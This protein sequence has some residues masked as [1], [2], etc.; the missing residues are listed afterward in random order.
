MSLKNH[1]PELKLSKNSKKLRDDLKI[2]HPI[3]GWIDCEPHCL[4]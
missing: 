4:Q 3:Q 1:L 2:L